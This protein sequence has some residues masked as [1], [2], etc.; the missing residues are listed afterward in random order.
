VGYFDKMK[1]NK[2][3]VDALNQ[4]LIDNGWSKSEG[5]RHFNV[6]VTAFIKWLNGGNIR[7]SQWLY[8]KNDIQ[9]Y[10]NPTPPEST[11]PDK[12]KEPY[13]N[14]KYI[15]E[16]DKSQFW[17]TEHFLRNTASVVKDKKMQKEIIPFKKNEVAEED[18]PYLKV[19]AGGGLINEPIE[20]AYQERSDIDRIGVDGESMEP[21]FK[22]GSSVLVHR[23]TQPVI[24]GEDYLPE[25]VVKAI[26]PD[27]SVIVYDLN[28]SGLAM[29]RIHYKEYKTGWL[30]VLHSDNKEWGKLNGFPRVLKKG[31][32]L[33]IYGKVL[34]D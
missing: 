2:K 33:R 9:K 19:S 18:I 11:I 22:N 32:D 6:S 23:L 20:R 8:V 31:D 27:H 30:L 7:E 5:A 17:I 26:I 10:L 1:S 13:D 12:L 29:K 24:F 16:S 14:L 34:T 3:I 21:T 28:D 4:L 15:Y 25:K